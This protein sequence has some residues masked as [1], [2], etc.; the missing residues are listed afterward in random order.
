MPSSHIDREKLTIR[1]MITL[2]CRAN[3][4]RASRLCS[5]CSDILNYAYAKIGACS[6][7]PGKKPA[8]GLCRSN[9]FD[10]NK[11][12]QLAQIMRKTGLRMLMH[13]PLLTIAHLGDAIRKRKKRGML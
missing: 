6:Y 2:Y 9:C 8:C 3:G 13:H 1:Y 10:V 5:G 11:R 12:G 4:H 7:L